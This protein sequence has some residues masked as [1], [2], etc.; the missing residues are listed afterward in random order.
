MK[1]KVSSAATL[2]LF[3]SAAHA[4]SSVTLYGVIDSGLLYQTTS[5]ASFSPKAANTGHVQQ[6]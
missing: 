1:L 4:Q 6:R 3:A 5:A 2:V